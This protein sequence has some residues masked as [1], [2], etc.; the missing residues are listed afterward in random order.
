MAALSLE[1]I[2]SRLTNRTVVAG[3]EV[4]VEH[5]KKVTGFLILLRGSARIME[6]SKTTRTR[7]ASRIVKVGRLEPGDLW[8]MQHMHHGKEA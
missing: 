2:A 1:R 7:S 5:G 4:L 6:V 8:G 3:G